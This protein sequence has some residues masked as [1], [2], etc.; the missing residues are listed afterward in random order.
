MMERPGP[1]STPPDVRISVSYGNQKQLLLATRGEIIVV[2]L[3]VQV[4]FKIFAAV[5]YL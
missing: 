3:A 5:G 2:I 4:E 1:V